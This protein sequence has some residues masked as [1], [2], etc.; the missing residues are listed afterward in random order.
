MPEAPEYPL[1]NRLR[2]TAVAERPQERLEKFGAGA[3][4]DTELLAMLLRS[5]TR[6]HDVLT[7]ATRLI[8]EAG[9]L[10]GLIVWRADDFEKLKGIGRVKA[11]QLVTVMEVARRV[12]GQQTG[13]SPLL[14]R[15][16]LVTAYFQPVV[17]GLEVE[18]FWVLCLNRKNRLIK[19]VEI[20]SGTATAALAHPREVFRA[21]IRES[22]TAVVCVHNHPSGDP[23]PSAADLQVTRQLREA[24]RAVDI[25]LLDHVIVGRS[26]ADPLG[27]GWFSFRDAGML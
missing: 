13:E 20:T 22:A 16:D 1:A 18:K 14:N 8:G 11:L 7:L 9:S 6:G 26:G 23:A 4:S 27:R 21:A 25:E 10:A 2:E 15:A 17:F 24:A 19:R 3:L 5:G 12:V